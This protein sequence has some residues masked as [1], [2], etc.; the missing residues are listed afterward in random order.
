M[1]HS[2]VISGTPVSYKNSQNIVTNR[3]TGGR[4]VLKS[5]AARSWKSDAV[6]QFIEQRGRR[7]TIQHPVAVTMRFYCARDVDCDNLAGG[8]LDAMQEAGVLADD[9]LVMELTVSK[10][11]DRDH[12][13]VEITIRAMEAA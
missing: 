11:K 1:T 9:A 6:R 5:R 13:R 8:P 4:F 3:K 2:Y 10:V 12:P 7:R